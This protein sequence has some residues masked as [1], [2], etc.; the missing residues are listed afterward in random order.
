L[1]YTYPSKKSMTST[2]RKVKS[3]TK[4]I[5]HQSADNL[6][7]QLGLMLRGWA[8]Y[9][10]HASSCAAYHDLQHFLW[11]RI[12]YWLLNK[13]SRTSKREIIQRYYN[14]WWPEYNGVTLYQPTTMTIQRY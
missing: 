14:G 10:R 9:L 5:T 4:R 11:W 3:V 6:F 2:K 8:Q 7:R 12:W 13:H 1:I